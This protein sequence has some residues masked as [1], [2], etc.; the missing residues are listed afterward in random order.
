MPA[1][2]L[3]TKF[4]HDPLKD[5][6]D[7][8]LPSGG[9][10][11]NQ[12]HISPK[13]HGMGKGPW[14]SEALKHLAFAVGYA[15]LYLAVRPFS[16]AH[17]ALTS[18]LRF[19][20]LLLV[21]TR[22]WPA[23]VV[24]EAVPLAYGVF[25]C[26][27]MYGYATAAIFAIPPIA[28][29]MPVVAFCRSH[30]KLFPAQRVIDMRVLLACSL[31]VSLL[32][33]L[34]TYIGFLVAVFPPEHPLQVRPMIIAGLFVGNYVAI[35]TVTTWPLL[36]KIAH[37][38][39]PWRSL[40]RQAAKA[41]LVWEAGAIGLPVL[42]ALSWC[43][44]VISPDGEH[45]VQMALFLPVAWLTLK[46]G[47]RG[48]AVIGPVTI[49]CVCLITHSA[50]D[51]IIIQT[52]AFVA[53]SVT[54]LFLLGARIAAQLHAQ[55]RERL[56]MQ[57][58]LRIAQRN[59]HQ[60]EQRLR[61]TSTMLDALGGTV[62]LMQGRVLHQVRHLLAPADRKSLST[63]MDTTQTRLHQLAEAMHPIA[64]RERGLPAALREAVGRVLDETGIHYTCEIRGRG[65]SVLAPAVHQAIYR[66]A[67]EA[68]THLCARHTCHEVRLILR[69]G[70]THGRRW[71]VLRVVGYHGPINGV[72][73]AYHGRDRLAIGSRLGLSSGT[74]AALE[75]QAVLFGGAVHHRQK[76]EAMMLT[77]LVHDAQPAAIVESDDDASCTPPM[78]WVR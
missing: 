42:I 17:W 33:A 75:D 71:A 41:S 10:S 65:L 78:L 15:A 31:S 43:S 6:R 76:G 23:L 58:T 37:H 19:T 40:L 64:W 67:C 18:G 55:E 36:W 8:Y 51:P 4:S 29:A 25:N 62:G 16:D 47:W 38:G 52:Q 53:F 7:W 20:V 73:L 68:V 3:H 21:P 12:H 63:L 45:V 1:D 60:S 30:L 14:R 11:G 61:Q 70:V 49:A 72:H 26:V 2:A 39:T 9:A 27:A 32:W 5:D 48:A 59:L 77:A 50:P 34:V 44:L 54:C 24:G 22:Y 57:R 56:A 35:L 74:V 46:Y 28:V 69:G 13:G 66:L